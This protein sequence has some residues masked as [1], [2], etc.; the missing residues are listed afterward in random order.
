MILVL[1][2][3]GLVAASMST[4]LAGTQ[5]E[6]TRFAQMSVGTHTLDV[7]REVKT[8]DL[9]FRWDEIPT[10]VW[11]Y[12]PKGS[13]LTKLADGRAVSRTRYPSSDAAWQAIRGRFGVTSKSVR[14][15]L[16]QGSPSPLPPIS[17]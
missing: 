7:W 14:A 11:R 12:A 10:T 8:H 13:T 16:L 2:V 6:P 5:D 15:A 3:G 17:G 1:V 9:L 4:I